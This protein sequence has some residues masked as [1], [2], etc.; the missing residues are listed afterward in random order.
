MH[1]I[2]APTLH[3]LRRNKTK[4]YFIVLQANSFH[5]FDHIKMVKGE[6]DAS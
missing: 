5:G 2:H 1:R 6:K 3:I 4:T